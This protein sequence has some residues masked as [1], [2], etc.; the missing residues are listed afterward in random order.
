MARL[1]PKFRQIQGGSVVPLAPPP[2]IG[3][4]TGGGFAYV[5]RGSAGG[6][7]QG[8]GAGAARPARSPP[9]RIPSC[10]GCSAPSRPPT[11]RSIS[12]STATRCRCWASSSSDV[13]QALQASLGGYYVNDMNLF[14]RTW[15]VQVQ[16]EASDRASDRRHLPHQCA[17][18][19]GQ[20]DPDAQPRRGARG[21][22]AARADPLQQPARRHRA[23]RAGAGR[24][25]RPGARGHGA[26]G[27][28]DAAAAASP[29]SGPTPRSR[30]S[31]PRARPASSSA[32]RCCSPSCSWW[33]STRA[34]PSR[35]RCCC[36]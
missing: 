9:T 4:G 24:L 15:Q 19:R 20:D 12:T 30:R 7:S 22:R 21:R 26:G 3:L 28:Q 27:G 10:R 23:G 35:C 29:A 14:G 2:I 34:G 11:R 36:R 31:A 18:Q 25:L 13:F 16:A 1:A 17:Q 6:R 33:R 32:S 8:A 5:L